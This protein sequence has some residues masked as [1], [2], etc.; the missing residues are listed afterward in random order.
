MV[1]LEAR[2]SIEG[3][4]L[5][6]DQPVAL[7]Q[8]APCHPV[9]SRSQRAGDLREESEGPVNLPRPPRRSGGCAARLE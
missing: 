2:P 7:A 8:A 3:G 5:P 6:S 9:P 1:E 4:G